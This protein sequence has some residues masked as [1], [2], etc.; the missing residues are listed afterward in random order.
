MFAADNPLRA[1]TAMRARAT[2]ALL[3]AGQVPF[4]R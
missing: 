4:E 3:V 1:L 2:Q